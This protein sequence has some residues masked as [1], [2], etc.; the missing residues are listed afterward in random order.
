MKLFIVLGAR[1]GAVIRNVC[2]DVDFEVVSLPGGSLIALLLGLYALL[3]RS[4][5][6]HSSGEPPRDPPLDALKCRAGFIGGR[7]RP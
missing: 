5:L 4:G 7:M 1:V 6:R 2:A 3:G